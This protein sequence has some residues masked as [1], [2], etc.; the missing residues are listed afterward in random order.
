M[1]TSA[2]RLPG[3]VHQRVEARRQPGRKQAH[4]F[5]A[6]ASLRAALRLNFPFLSGAKAR[7]LFSSICGTTKVVPFKT[8]E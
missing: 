3:I 2:E 8:T 5:I 6:H 1:G 7:V 4:G